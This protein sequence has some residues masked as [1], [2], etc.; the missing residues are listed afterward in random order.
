MSMPAASRKNQD[1]QPK[2]WL[3]ASATR[4][5]GRAVGLVQDQGE[6][7]QLRGARR[8]APVQPLRHSE[9]DPTVGWFF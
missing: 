1:W 8:Q 3:T 7:L 2:R 4:C 6:L 9:P 5:A